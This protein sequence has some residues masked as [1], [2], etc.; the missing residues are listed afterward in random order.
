VHADDMRILGIPRCKANSCNHL[1]QSR[2]G[3]HK[4][5]KAHPLLGR[6]QFNAL[7]GPFFTFLGTPQ[8]SRLV[9]LTSVVRVQPRTFKGITDLLLA[10]A[11]VQLKFRNLHGPLKKHVPPEKPTE[12]TIQG[13]HRQFEGSPWAASK[14]F[15]TVFPR[16]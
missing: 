9:H 10:L 13:R 4:I 8:C 11:C 14:L 15:S 3:F 16:Y 12:T 6:G 1:S 2:Q 7:Q 5:S